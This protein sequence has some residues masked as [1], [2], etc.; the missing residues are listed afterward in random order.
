MEEE[1]RFQRFGRIHNT[2]C[3][4]PERVIARIVDVTETMLRARGATEVERKGDVRASIE[5]GNGHILTATGPDLAWRAYIHGEDRVGV[6][7]ARARSSTSVPRRGRTPS[8]SPWRDRLPLRVASARRSRAVVHGA[9]H[10][11]HH[12]RPLCCTQTRA[13]HGG[14]A[15]LRESVPTTFPP[16]SSPTGSCESPRLAT[17]EHR[18]HHAR[19]WWQRTHPYLPVGDSV[20][21]VLVCVCVRPETFGGF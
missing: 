11:R 15:S 3:G 21:G 6:K 20:R 2:I 19:L 18:A 12:R 16:W 14:P 1:Q 9:G 7:Y 5:D 10:V 4:D 17:R 8:S 13:H